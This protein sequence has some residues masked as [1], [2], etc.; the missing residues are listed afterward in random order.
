[1]QI[2][3]LSLCFAFVLFSSQVLF[4]SVIDSRILNHPEYSLPPSTYEVEVLRLVNNERTKRGLVPLTWSAK[5]GHSARY[6][7]MD[8]LINGCFSHANC[9][10]GTFRDRFTYFYGPI[11]NW[12][13]ENIVRGPTPANVMERWMKSRGHRR[14]ILLP[15]FR[16]IGIGFVGTQATQT[17]AAQSSPGDTHSLP[18]NPVPPI[19]LEG[20]VAASLARA[21]ALGDS[22]RLALDLIAEDSDQNPIPKTRVTITF[23][24]LTNPLQNDVVRTIRTNREGLAHSNFVFSKEKNSGDYRVS[25]SA[26]REGY[27]LAVQSSI[28]ATVPTP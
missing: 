11:L 28:P 16:Y 8:M 27:N 23:H 3:I 13:G 25:I 10:A 24:P 5:L 18:A 9:G 1:M 4:A 15:E 2:K 19:V 6:H 14:N 22:Y 12:A 20:T 21:P 26:E 17:F 7:S